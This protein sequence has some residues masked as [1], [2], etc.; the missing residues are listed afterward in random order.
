[1]QMPMVWMG[2][3]QGKRL[4]RRV[5]GLDVMLNLCEHSRAEKFSHFLYAGVPGITDALPRNLQE[6]FPGL[7]IAGTFSPPFRQL[8]NVEVSEL[9]RRVRET[10]P[11]FFGVGLSTP[12]QERFMAEFANRVWRGKTS[13][14]GVQF[15]TRPNDW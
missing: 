6:R 13:W 3:L 15:G 8:N 5:Y 1:M 12:K 9:Q 11:D 14:H 4:I 2:R 10:C 7:N